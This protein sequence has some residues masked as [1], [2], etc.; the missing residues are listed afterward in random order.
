MDNLKARG[1]E[2]IVKGVAPSKSIDLERYKGQ[3]LPNNWEIEGVTGDVLLC[4]FS[5]TADKDGEYVDRGGVLISTDVTRE[6]WRVARIV[7]SGPGASI[8]AQAGKYILFPNDR[9]IPMTKFDGKDYIFINEERILA[10]VKPR[11]EDKDTMI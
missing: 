11:S 7:F 3:H 2:D 5:D 1:Q 10:F 4:E 8:N 6:M 9:G